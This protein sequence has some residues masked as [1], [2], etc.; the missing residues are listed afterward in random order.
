MKSKGGQETLQKVA[1]LQTKNATIKDLMLYSIADVGQVHTV[2]LEACQP[3]LREVPPYLSNIETFVILRL[4]HNSIRK[5]P[6]DL[7]KC[8]KLESMNFGWNH[9]SLIDE[10]MFGERAFPLLEVINLNHNRLTALPANFG[11]TSSPNR[12]R[13]IDLSENTLLAVPDSLRCC[14]NLFFLNISHNRIKKLPSPFL[15]KKLEKLFMSFNELCEL[16]DDLGECRELKKI[17]MQHNQVKRLPDTM[18]N[19]REKL[20][21][22]LV[23]NNPLTVPSITAFEM[24]GLQQAFALLEEHVRR[25]HADSLPALTAAPEQAALALELKVNQEAD[26]ELQRKNKK[27]RDELGVLDDYYFGHSQCK[28]EFGSYSKSKVKEIRHAESTLLIIKKNLY[29]QS[30]V[31]LA[32]EAKKLGEDNVPANMKKF[33]D[34]KFDVSKWYGVS[35]V[36]DLDLYFNLVVYSTRPLFSN[37]FTLFDKFEK[38][39]KGYLTK[40]EWT[41]FVMWCPVLLQDPK[42]HEGM[43][44]LMAWRSSDR[45]YIADFIA[46][47]HIHDVEHI[48]PQIQRCAQ[49]LRLDYYDMGIQELQDRLHS[50]DAEDAAPKLDFDEDSD[51]ASDKEGGAVAQMPRGEG[52]RWVIQTKAVPEGSGKKKGDKE[53]EK[54][55]ARVSSS[56]QQDKL[57]SLTDA[58]WAEYEQNHEGDNVSEGEKSDISARS[59]ELSEDS[60][61]ELNG[62]SEP[63][64]VDDHLMGMGVNAQDDR[65]GVMQV[66][67]DDDI[68]ALMDAPP[69]SFFK[70]RGKKKPHALVDA[71]AMLPQKDV[72]KGKKQTTKVQND[73][74]FKTDVYPVRQEIRRVFRNLPYDDFVKLINFLLRG[75]QMIKHSRKSGTYWHADDPTFKFTMGA[76]GSNMYTRRLLCDMGFAVVDNLYWVW[77]VIHMEEVQ[78]LIKNGIPVWGDEEIPRSCPGRSEDR[79]DDMI[80]LLRNCQKKLHK[81]GKAFKGNFR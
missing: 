43:W 80:N 41:D 27:H 53:A 1:M 62:Y 57:C 10:D 34:P 68:R 38:E 13:H 50:K 4:I 23:S 75:M 21:E 56:S 22:F 54:T 63:F 32:Q 3:P 65:S 79:L 66:R 60:D 33:L 45:I 81:L 47:W 64:L 12:I 44:Q 49:V 18:L 61:N 58:Q 26:A 17:R 28:D 73:S 37:C 29:F 46:A 52:E 20:Q 70:N 71:K 78:K 6:G 24:G 42:V 31:A 25:A 35:H 8:S 2:D 67:G 59:S 14:R 30:Q 5:L 39:V 72:P 48:D 40:D 11:H 76:S 15:Y 19:L 69:S 77:P 55:E 36:T 16:P 7:G 74:H 9:V 51:D